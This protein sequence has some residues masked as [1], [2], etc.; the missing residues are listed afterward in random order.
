MSLKF[1]EDKYKTIPICI[2]AIKNNVTAIHYIP[3]ELKNEGFYKEILKDN[4]TAIKYID[5]D[6]RSDDICLIAILSYYNN[7]NDIS[8]EDTIKKFDSYI[9]NGCS[10]SLINNLKEKYILN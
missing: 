7:N 4:P 10:N 8:L 5:K 1:I 3:N 2:E 6:H 9:P